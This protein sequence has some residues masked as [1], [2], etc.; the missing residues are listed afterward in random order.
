MNNNTA[1]QRWQR[2]EARNLDT[3][4][5]ETVKEGMKCPPFIAEAIRQ[6]VHEV[7]APLLET[8]DTLQPGQL[9]LSVIDARVAPNTPLTQAKQCLVTLT[10]D[11][12]TEDRLVRQQAG[13]V[14]LR[15]HRMLR[16]CE[17]AFQQGGLLT[18]EAIADLFNCGVR[19]L[20]DDFAVVRAQGHVP[21]LRSTVKDM[22]RAITHRTLIVTHWLQGKEYTE[23][24]F[25]T[26]HTVL[27][28]SNYV[29]KY[30]RCATL[31][32]M[33]FD[34][35]TVALIARLSLGIVD[36]FQQIA[37]QVQPVAHRQQELA[38]LCR[39]KNMPPTPKGAQR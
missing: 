30:K 27:S 26:H 4:F 14:G 28:V 2:S 18:L 5:V 31:F 1:L 7:Y 13:I 3:P 9:R 11:A 36:A 37:A 22:G 39:K 17:E 32:A 24:A 33:G 10:L 29:E 20:V 38:D 19:T 23:I 15:Q 16:I 8:T 25:Q 34:G 12:G 21:P 35:E 6:V